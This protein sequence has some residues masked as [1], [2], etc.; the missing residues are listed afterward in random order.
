MFSCVVILIAKLLAVDAHE[1]YNGVCPSFTSMEGWDWRD[2]KG[3]WKVAFKMNSRSSCIRYSFQEKGN[4]RVVI[5]QK[6]LPVL[7]RFGIPSAVMSKGTLSQVSA[8]SAEMWVR[9]D[10]GV[11]REAMFSRM[12]YVVLDTDY[13]TNALVCSCQDLNIGIFAVNRRS[14]DF[15]VRPSE[16]VPPTIPSRYT[17]LLNQTSPD[18][19]L[20]MK[21]VRQDDCED[22]GKASLDVG[23]WVT[24]ARTYGDTAIQMA[25]EMFDY[26]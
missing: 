23:F 25:K 5:E 3:E 2:F 15:L 19:S 17:S 11:L 24:Q 12:K 26:N 16:I 1:Y 22:L 4:T 8:K 13:D 21:R 10:T 18:L 14:C 6:L 7:G 20:D 9:W